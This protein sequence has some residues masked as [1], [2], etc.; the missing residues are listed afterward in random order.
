[1]GSDVELTA[2]SAP[3]FVKSDHVQTTDMNAS[4][5]SELSNSQI[6]AAIADITNSFIAA[7][8]A[9]G[10]MERYSYLYH[11]WIEMV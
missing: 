2:F 9:H 7:L 5:T 6:N 1:V 3:L 4:S 8:S 11:L 10:L